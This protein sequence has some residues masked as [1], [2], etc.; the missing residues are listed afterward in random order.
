M[1]RFYLLIIFIFSIT[2]AKALSSYADIVE[3]LMPSVVNIS[4]KKEVVEENESIDNVMLNKELDS[5]ESL[6]S[7][8]FI[9]NAE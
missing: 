8:F 6:G 7:G 5:R 9:S 3:E 1:H 2:E 4:T